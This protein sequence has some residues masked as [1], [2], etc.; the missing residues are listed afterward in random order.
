[1]GLGARLAGFYCYGLRIWASGNWPLLNL[2]DNTWLH[3]IGDIRRHD[4]AE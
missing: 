4:S 3:A 1:M 2:I